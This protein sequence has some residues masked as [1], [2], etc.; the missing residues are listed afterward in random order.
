MSPHTME[1]LAHRQVLLWNLLHRALAP[2]V[3]A[4]HM[5]DWIY[6]KGEEN[7]YRVC[8]VREVQ[9]NRSGCKFRCVRGQSLRLVFIATK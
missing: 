8:E 6:E 7:Y 4:S 1:A 2:V 5:V 9:R 3:L